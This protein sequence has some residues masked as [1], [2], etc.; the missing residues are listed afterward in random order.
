MAHLR[1]SGCGTLCDQTELPLPNLLFDENGCTGSEVAVPA[2]LCCPSCSPAPAGHQTD[3]GKSLC[4]SSG[5]TRLAELA[6]VSRISPA[7]VSSSVAHTAEERPSLPSSRDDLAP[8]T[9]V[10]GQTC[11]ENRP[12]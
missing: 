10:G 11:S 4:C 7:T 8:P 9:G 12:R 2:P 1:S 5:D 6:M 3:T